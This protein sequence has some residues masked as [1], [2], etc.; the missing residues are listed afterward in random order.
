MDAQTRTLVKHSQKVAALKAALA[1]AKKSYDEATDAMLAALKTARLDEF[2]TD[3]GKFASVTPAKTTIDN[4]AVAKLVKYQEFV[5][6]A[7]VSIPKA[8]EILTPAEFDS[9]TKTTE[10]ASY[11]KVTLA[12]EPDGE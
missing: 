6:L 3:A 2:E 1:E 5:A 11:L 12:G 9:V 8:R 7:K 4:K 10:G